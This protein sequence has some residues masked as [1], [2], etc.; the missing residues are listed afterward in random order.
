MFL[1]LTLEQIAGDERSCLQTVLDSDTE[2]AQI[3]E[4]LDELTENADIPASEGYENTAEEIQELCER[5]AELD[6][7]S[8]E[9][10]AS[11]IL[12][13]LG[14]SQSIMHQPA[15]TLS[16][17]WRTRL[18]LACALFMRPDILMLDEPTNHLDLEGI[19]CTL[20]FSAESEM[21]HSFAFAIHRVGGISPKD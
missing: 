6:V 15:S 10:R 18:A 16:G 14:F 9:A 8:A 7:Q 11:K 17:G 13:G 1:D 19:I 12:R 5:L 4:R 20:I 21:I 2:A 3:N